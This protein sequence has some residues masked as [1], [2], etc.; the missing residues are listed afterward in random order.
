MIAQFNKIWCVCVCVCVWAYACAIARHSRPGLR[1]EKFDVVSND[2]GRTQKCDFC[3][4][5]GKT[6]FTDHLTPNTIKGFSDSVL[7]TTDYAKIP[8]IPFFS[9]DLLTLIKRQAIAMVT[10]NEKKP[11]QNAF[12]LAFK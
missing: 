4:S 2:H 12:K 5:V 6:K 11:L 3:V 9:S 1:S 10:L 8:S 7:V